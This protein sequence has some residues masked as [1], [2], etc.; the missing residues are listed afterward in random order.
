M[1]LPPPPR[2]FKDLSDEEIIRLAVGMGEIKSIRNRLRMADSIPTG[3][4]QN[5]IE[6]YV[7]KTLRGNDPNLRDAPEKF[8]AIA[9][10]TFPPLPENEY[11]DSDKGG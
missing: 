6:G 2:D 11:D 4:M 8:V 5:E 7:R 3:Q 1:P 9:R 10:L